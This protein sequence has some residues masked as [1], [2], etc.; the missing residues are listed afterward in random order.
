MTTIVKIEALCD[1]NT[2][3]VNVI[4][5][6]ATSVV[7]SYVLQDGE[8]SERYVYDDRV[9]TIKETLKEK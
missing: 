3:E 6:D 8:S 5:T 2:T 1:E 9:I 4:I 7:E